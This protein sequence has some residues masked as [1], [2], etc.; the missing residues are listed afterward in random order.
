MGLALVQ[1]QSLKQKLTP[2]LFQ[3]VT[4]LQFNHE[5]LSDYIK[6][7][8]TGNPLLHVGE[9]DFGYTPAHSV[10][11]E[12]AR[13]TTDV[14]EETV[15]SP[16]SFRDQLHMDLH[17]LSL[18]KNGIAAADLLIDCLDQ[19]GYLTENPAE[20]L[21]RFGMD[22][23]LAEQAL[24]VVQTLEPA[25]VG[26]RTL[27][28]CLRLQLERMEPRSP[29]AEKIISDFSDYFLSGSWQELAG[30]L[31]ISEKQVKEAVALIRTLDPAP[32]HDHTGQQTPYVFPDVVVRR[33][34]NGLVCE[35]ED[36]LLP[37]I[38]LE[39]GVYRA[40]MTQ[41]DRETKRYLKQ[42]KAEAQWLL[43]GLSRRKKTVLQ[44]STLLV[45]K[46]ADF[47]RTGDMGTLRPFMM[48]EA[49]QAMSVNESTISRAVA[50]KYLQ[51][52]YGL[53]P[54]KTF[55]VRPMKKNRQEISSHQII[56]RIKALIDEEDPGKPYS[57]Q[58]LARRISESGYRL[59]RRT[60]AKYREAS[61]IGS[62]ILR[63]KR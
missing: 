27:Q 49:A 38:T 31:G 26:A 25:G 6:E 57:D 52:P 29:L 5:Q 43:N 30:K 47:F 41:A 51:T 23:D 56:S 58:E 46:Q 34:E 44:L 22:S 13:S 7:K 17:Q 10:A 53:F 1:N 33:T 59:S 37:K 54:I 61:G 48:K 2:A 12:E 3:S 21:D 36:R 45:D 28:E 40:Y 11:G 20:I 50:N 14:I 4:L 62:T 9:T 39:T 16:G 32:V 19:N 42:K 8:A 35:L 24:Q 15:Q 55:F 63:R 18:S 60:V